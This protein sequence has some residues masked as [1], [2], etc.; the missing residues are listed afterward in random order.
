MFL[1]NAQA[2]YKPQEPK[3][4]TTREPK[5]TTSTAAPSG[6]KNLL[7]LEE[8]TLKAVLAGSVAALN[9]PLAYSYR[10]TAQLASAALPRPVSATVGG[11]YF[12]PP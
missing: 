11:I 6:T 3:V 1:Q 2:L 7:R 9:A 10:P 4:Q 12:A 8:A 5:T